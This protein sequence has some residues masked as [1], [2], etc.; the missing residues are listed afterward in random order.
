MATG[1]KGGGPEKPLQED[2]ILARLVDDSTQITAGL[3]SY[4]GL[5]GRSPKAG[6]WLLY[7]SLDMSL[8]V[9][10][11]EEDIV[12]S[13]QLS[14]DK[15]SFGVLGGT[16]VFVKKDAKVTTTR[17]I[18]RT[19]E[20]GAG[21]DEFDLDIR[22]GG[23]AALPQQCFGT[24]AGTTCAAECGGGGTGDAGTC[25]TC[26]SCGDTCFRTCR[27]TCRTSATRVQVMPRQTQ[28]LQPDCNTCNT[29]CGRARAVRVNSM[30]NQ[31]LC[32]KSG[33][34]RL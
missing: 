34:T 28:H 14:A 19:H 25:L 23:R 31:Q 16:Q 6:S 7:L 17:T 21:G 2:R 12:H 8:C 26:V 29:Q 11:R 22:L 32:I 30:W 24:E 3:T 13:E 15:S 10:I 5:L 20:A 33:L 4:T 9:E 18:S 27:D 1:K